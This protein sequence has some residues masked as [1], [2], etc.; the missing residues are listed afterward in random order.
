MVV[1][2]VIL[3]ETNTVPCLL[4]TF[5]FG[6]KCACRD[7]QTQEFTIRSLLLS[8]GWMEGEFTG[9]YKRP[10]Q[11]QDIKFIRTSLKYL[12]TKDFH[13]CAS[14]EPTEIPDNRTASRTH[15]VVT[16][17]ACMSTTGYPDS[18][19]STHL[20]LTSK[21]IAFKALIL[22]LNLFL[23]WKLGCLNRNGVINIAFSGFPQ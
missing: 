6:C 20:Q 14:P 19:I 4:F 18:D 2:A 23:S 13:L 1:C 11:W 22:N 10:D 15:V 3:F 17:P 16:P 8:I 21:Q 5:L 9:L 7:S 12:W